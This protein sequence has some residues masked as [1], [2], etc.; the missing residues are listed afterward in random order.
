MTTHILRGHTI[1]VH[2]IQAREFQ[3]LYGIHLVAS[4]LDHPKG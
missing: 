1:P 4:A 3:C 2:E